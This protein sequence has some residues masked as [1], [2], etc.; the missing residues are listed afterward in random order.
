MKKSRHI[1]HMDT[2]VTGHRN[3]SL[4][5]RQDSV[6]DRTSDLRGALIFNTALT[7]F[8]LFAMLTHRTGGFFQYEIGRDALARIAGGIVLLRGLGIHLVRDQDAAAEVCRRLLE[9]GAAPGVLLA[10]ATQPFDVAAFTSR[11]SERRIRIADMIG[12]RGRFITLALAG[13]FYLYWRVATEP[14]AG[15]ATLFLQD[16]LFDAVVTSWVFLGLL[17]CRTASSRRRSTGRSPASWTA[18]SRARTACSS[19]R[20]GRRSSS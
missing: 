4:P 7:A 5:N 9:G 3:A 17:L 11:H 15:F 1:S 16:N 19:R 20:C 14:I 10:H 13:F 18:C 12:R 8:W 6:A 2:A